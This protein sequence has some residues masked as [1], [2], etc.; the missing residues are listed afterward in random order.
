ML[1]HSPSFTRFSHPDT[2]RQ[3][4]T[5]GAAALAHVALLFSTP[6]LAANLQSAS[7]TSEQTPT[8]QQGTIFSPRTRERDREQPSSREEMLKNVEIKRREQ[9]HKENLERARENAELGAELCQTFARQKSL[10]AAEQKKLGR[11]EKLSRAIRNEAGG[12]DDD[13]EEAKEIPPSLEASLARVQELSA[14]LQKKVEKT[15]RHVV[16]TAVIGTANR[17][18]ELIR[19]IRASAK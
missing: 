12:G 15:P 5:F 7:R 2:R 8:A 1:K 11:M 3:R 16:S 9:S 4:L 19:H 10:G 17:L 6:S 13:K 14:E 18:I